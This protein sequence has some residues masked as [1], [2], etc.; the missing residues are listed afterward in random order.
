MKAVII[1]VYFGKL[2][3][4]I[5]YFVHSC[6]FNR[7]IDWIV[8]T[9]QTN[10]PTAPANLRFLPLSQD[11]FR[12]RVFEKLRIERGILSP[13]KICD[14]RPTF[15]ILFEDY[16][17]GYDFWGHCDLD[18]IF[19]DLQL[20]LSNHNLAK[21]DIIS[22][23]MKRHMS[24]HLSLYRNC[25]LLNNAFRRYQGYDRI[26]SAPEHFGFDE[27]ERNNDA[28]GGITRVLRSMEAAN[29]IAPLWKE[30]AV[31][32]TPD[33]AKRRMHL[34]GRHPGILSPDDYWLWTRGKLYFKGNMSMPVPYLHFKNWK[35]EPGFS[36]IPPPASDNF[37]IR[38]DGI[39]NC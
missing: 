16:L 32:Y 28:P 9:D 39:D 24:G 10:A 13:R 3:P 27:A 22:S 31:S 11:A 19:G 20:L 2:P 21:Y 15:G 35:D 30:N 37:I 36:R 1:V 7:D 23:R 6:A 17:F 33:I 8:F 5:D 34:L 18:L 14:F 4:W 12:S 38:I 26:L 29:E 25:D